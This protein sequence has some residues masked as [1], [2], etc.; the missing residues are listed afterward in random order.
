M[1]EPHRIVEAVRRGCSQADSREPARDVE[2]ACL[3]CPEFC[4]VSHPWRPRPAAPPARPGVDREGPGG[5]CLPGRRTLLV[6]A[7]R[8]HIGEVK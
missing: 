2:T 7:L 6:R 3:L 1:A 4:E 8:A 5:F